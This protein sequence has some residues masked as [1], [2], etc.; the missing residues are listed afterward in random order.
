MA[1]AAAQHPHRAAQRV[2]GLQGQQARRDARAR[3]EQNEPLTRAFRAGQHG[4]DCPEVD[5]LTAGPAAR[6]RV[7]GA[8]TTEFWV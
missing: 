7:S 4:G 6:D 8:A 2:P 1:R 5:G 3:H